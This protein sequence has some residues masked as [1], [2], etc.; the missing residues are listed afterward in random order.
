MIGIPNR[1][2]C[3]RF[4]EK[5]SNEQN[6]GNSRD[7]EDIFQVTIQ[8]FIEMIRKHLSDKFVLTGNAM[9]QP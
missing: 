7:A 3:N 1:T 9:P 6:N 4:P 5:I 8:T 2:G